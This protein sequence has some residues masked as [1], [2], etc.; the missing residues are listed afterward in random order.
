VSRIAFPALLS[1]VSR[2]AFKGEESIPLRQGVSLI[3]LLC[4]GGVRVGEAVLQQLSIPM[5]SDRMEHKMNIAK[6][7]EAGQA[8]YSPAVLAIYDFYVFGLSN[9]YIWKCNTGNLIQNYNDNISNNHLEIGVG[10]GFLLDRCRFPVA[11]P[12][13]TLMDLN[14]N[15]LKVTEKRIDRYA[16][17]SFRQNV[18]EP[19]SIGP[20]KY[21]SVGINYLL[22]CLPG[23]MR[24]KAVVFDN[25]VDVL[26]TGGVVFGATLVQTGA[27]VGALAKIVM[28]IYNRQGI[29]SNTM[30]GVDDLDAILSTR[31]AQHSIDVCGCAAIFAA[32]L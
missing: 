14:V 9:R 29:F 24:S 18:L 11:M 7:V 20:H 16:P 22:H 8:I 2:I 3:K 10:S 32:R 23:A 15:T 28:N 26:N 27:P 17:T 5:H 6:E 1:W 21:D 13:V 4:G 12:R 30:D 19:F 31:F 25:I